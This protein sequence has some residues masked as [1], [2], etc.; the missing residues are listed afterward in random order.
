MDNKEDLLPVN[1]NYYIFGGCL[2]LIFTILFINLA[3][4]SFLKQ[5]EDKPI[6]QQLVT[7]T[8]K[9]LPQADVILYNQD[10][11]G[12]KIPNFIEDELMINTFISEISYCEQVN[13]SCNSRLDGE[14][15]YFSFLVDSGTSMSSPSS[16]VNKLG[17]I[18]PN[19]R[20]FVIDNFRINKFIQT[21]IRTFGNSGQTSPI[22]DAESC[23]STQQILNFGQAPLT[24]LF[25]NYKANGNSPIILAIEEAEKN[26]PNKEAQNV[27][28]LIT[29]GID[30]CNPNNLQNAFKSILDRKIVKR[31]NVISTYSKEFEEGILK[32]ATENNGGSFI[33]AES[34]K[35]LEEIRQVVRSSILTKWCRFQDQDIRNK[36]VENNYSKALKSLEDKLSKSTFEN[37][38]SKIREVISSINFTIQSYKSQKNIELRNESLEQIKF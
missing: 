26:F 3:I 4:Q 11:D 19:L 34:V 29:D 1:R 6:D 22:S 28:V 18:F 13:P 14:I 32:S 37:E 25:S 12:D 35:T 21:E 31:I 2:T 16:G 17:E 20:S 23:V 8:E 5:E 9:T 38:K 24:D 36:C 7:V 30:D 27:I 15:F 10:S 33:V